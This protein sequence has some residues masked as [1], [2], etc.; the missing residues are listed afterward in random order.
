MVAYK[1]RKI[2][3]EATN[4]AL[5]LIP[6]FRTLELWRNEFMLFKPSTPWFFVMVPHQSNT[7]I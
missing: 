4:P 7:D 2:A 6:D 3:S 1:P 5:K